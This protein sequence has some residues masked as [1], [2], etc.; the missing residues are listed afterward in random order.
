[1]LDNVKDIFLALP[2]RGWEV[3]RVKNPYLVLYLVLDGYI[4]A[5]YT[6]YPMV[7]QARLTGKGRKE[8]NAYLQSD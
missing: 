6:P 2:D 8:R 1:M 7:Y 3:I 5:Q 4:K